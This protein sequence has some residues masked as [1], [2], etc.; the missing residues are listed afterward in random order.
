M[1]VMLEKLKKVL[2]AIETLPGTCEE[3]GLEVMGVFNAVYAPEFE[4]TIHLLTLGNLSVPRYFPNCRRPIL[5]FSTYIRGSGTAVD[6]PPVER[7]LYLAAG[8][9]ETINTGVSVAY[10]FTSDK[11]LWEWL[12]CNFWYVDG[13]NDYVVRMCGCVLTGVMRFEPCQPGIIDWRLEGIFREI[14]PISNKHDFYGEGASPAIVAATVDEPQP[15]TCMDGCITIGSY[16]GMVNNLFDF[17]IGN[18]INTRPTFCKEHGH[19]IPYISERISVGN[20]QTEILLPVTEFDIQGAIVDGD[21][22]TISLAVGSVAGNQYTISV[23]AQLLNLTESPN[24]GI[25]GWNVAYGA[26]DIQDADFSL[27]FT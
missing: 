3:S 26:V 19:E 17:D 13:G 4:S 27:I 1:A 22:N 14:A 11:T 9:E 10:T 23:E 18:T 16:T 21:V 8:M 20:I 5:T 24:T 6:D 12:T 2:F 7:P 25:S 15:P